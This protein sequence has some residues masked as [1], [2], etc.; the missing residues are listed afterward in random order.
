MFLAALLALTPSYAGKD[1]AVTTLQT[2]LCSDPERR[3]CWRPQPSTEFHAWWV[4][5]TNEE[6]THLRAMPSRF[7]GPGPACVDG[8]P[9][10]WPGLEVYV[11]TD[12]LVPVATAAVTISSGETYV[13]VRPGL[14]LSGEPG[15]WTPL[16]SPPTRQDGGMVQLKLSDQ[17]VA[18]VVEHRP[19][20]IT[21]VLQLTVRP[22]HI[23]GHLLDH[24]VVFTDV[25]WM[26]HMTG[27]EKKKKQWYL[28]MSERC[29][30]YRVAV[31]EK[32][33]HE[34]VPPQGTP[35]VFDG[36]ILIP[37]GTAVSWAETGRPA[38]TLS[39]EIHVSSVEALERGNQT[40]WQRAVGFM[41]VSGYASMK[42]C[43]PTA[44]IQ[45][46]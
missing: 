44:S 16:I 14:P 22:G 42:L 2:H 32:L 41:E 38:G 34:R 29:S 19:S 33:S 46:I 43:I 35:D 24:P 12:E 25:P 10:A 23:M 4:V 5:S 30:S 36:D 37:A 21:E 18:R 1:I 3:N 28:T 7:A 15:A 45:K 20:H 13:Q 11:A 9:S 40:C 8:L 27:Y 31:P 39:Q 17:V 26:W 6:T